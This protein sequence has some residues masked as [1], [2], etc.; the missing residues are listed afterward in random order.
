MWVRAIHQDRLKRLLGRAALEGAI[1]KSPTAWEW[2]RSF[3]CDAPRLIRLVGRPDHEGRSQVVA[4][5]DPAYFLDIKVPCRQC[6]ACL[7]ARRRKWTA[8]SIIEV[9]AAARTWMLTLTWSPEGHAWL[10]EDET[11]RKHYREVQRFWKRL[12]KNTGVKFR[13]LCV[14]EKHKSGLWHAH[15]IVHEFPS[16][17]IRWRC[18]EAAWKSGFFQAKLLDRGEAASYACKYLAKSDDI[19]RIR[20]SVRYGLCPKPASSD[21][22]NVLARPCEGS[23]VGGSKTLT[24][25]EDEEAI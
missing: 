2:D 6:A 3:W 18:F 22:A 25:T 4:S 5:A 14:F 7:L 15:A 17:P 16:A 21:S 1:R 20:A 8:R 12:R 13:Y 11:S 9:G 23:P 10:D 24:R 19:A